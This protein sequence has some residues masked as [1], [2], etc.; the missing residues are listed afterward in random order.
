MALFSKK[1]VILLGIVLFCIKAAGIGEELFAREGGAHLVYGTKDTPD[2]LDVTESGLPIVYAIAWNYLDPLVRKKSGETGYYSGLAKKW[3]VSPDC[4]TYTFHLRKDVRFHDGTPLTADAVKAGIERLVK[5]GA[6]ASPDGSKAEQALWPLLHCETVDE[7]TVRVL[8]EKPCG[9]FL[10]AASTVYIPIISPR[11]LERQR[12]GGG[13]SAV[14]TGPFVLEEYVKGDHVTFVRNESYEWGPEWTH[15]G[16]AHIERLTYRFIPEEIV[17][18]AVLRGNE[19]DI[20]DGIS[21]GQTSRVLRDKRLG[22]GISGFRGAPWCLLLNCHRFPTDDRSVRQAVSYA[23]DRESI[24]DR[25]FKG[26]SDPAFSPLEKETF[27]YHRSVESLTVYDPE[28]A[29][30]ILDHAGWNRGADGV[31]EKEGKRLFMNALAPAGQREAAW[32]VAAQL[33]TI[34]ITLR[35]N[36]TES[37]ELL[38]ETGVAAQNVLFTC[39]YRPDPQFLTEWISSFPN[40][41]GGRP[42]YINPRLSDLLAEAEA[43][44]DQSERAAIYRTI[45]DIL[46]IEAVCI[47]L[48]E[49]SMV[50]GFRK[51]VC[52]I[53]YSPTGYPLFY[54]VS[55]AE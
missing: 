25:L 31:R 37:E 54:G 21:E 6:S 35:V 28:R 39:R 38:R 46:L 49:K 18:I 1:G 15:G 34:G 2:T 36:V 7:H 16:P 22:I 24:V 45:Q 30:D 41:E 33:E 17:R 52:G 48:Y 26:T 12:A 10:S 11:A 42:Y 44:T 32:E 20:I 53:T 5:G 14:G 55:I 8:F 50:L 9:F 47:P 29:V 51:D 4:K 23:I 3:T 19:A 13:F 27:G 43:K 40:K